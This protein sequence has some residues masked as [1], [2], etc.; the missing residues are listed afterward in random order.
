[1]DNINN[2]VNTSAQSNQVA[3]NQSSIDTNLDLMKKISENK[4]SFS[5]IEM[6]T[7]SKITDQLKVF[8]IAQ[9]RNEL[10]RVLKLTKFL[11]RLETS[12]MDKVDSAIQSDSLTLRQYNDIIN[13]TTS[14]LSRSNEII[15]KV[16][17]DDSLTMIMNTT[18]YQT[19]TSSQTSS[20]VVANLKDPQSREKVRN[21][22][23]QILRNT[24]SYDSPIPTEGVEIEDAK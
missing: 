14:L 10:N 22:I 17:K 19:D 3:N 5:D 8:L 18:V 12:F 2:L 20:S 21:V 23:Q 1:M 7:S 4:Q 13:V 6:L 16:L 9:A 15:S 24:N 11:D